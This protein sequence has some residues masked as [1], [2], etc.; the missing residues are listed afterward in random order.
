MVSL[1]HLSQLDFQYQWIA[2]LL[3]IATTVAMVT[4][5]VYC[6]CCEMLFNR[7]AKPSLSTLKKLVPDNK[8][9]K[10]AATQKG[11]SPAIGAKQSQPVQQPAT[12]S[13]G[14]RKQK[15]G[16]KQKSLGRLQVHFSYKRSKTTLDVTIMCAENL[17][18]KDVSGTSDPYC[19]LLL[20]PQQDKKIST[21][22]KSRTLNPVWNET[23]PLAVGPAE[24]NEQTLYVYVLDHDVMNKDDMIGECRFNLSALEH[25]ARGQTVWRDIRPSEGYASHLGELLLSLC[26]MASNEKLTINILKCTNLKAMDSNN[27]SDP[28]VKLFIWKNGKKTHKQKTKVIYRNRNP[29]FNES[30]TF[31]VGLSKIQTTKI[32]VQVMDYDRMSQNDKIGCLMLGSVGDLHAAQHWKEMCEKMDKPIAQW[33]RLKADIDS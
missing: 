13:T 28:Y 4:A 26:Y 33:Y 1:D 32:L 16:P 15:K 27:L 7:S 6:S 23:I 12:S 24:L 20:L 11:T 9:K 19:K 25:I 21:N 2:V 31:E 3:T 18:A 10:L 5:V 17:P 29:V 8:G 22:Y 14:K 30:F